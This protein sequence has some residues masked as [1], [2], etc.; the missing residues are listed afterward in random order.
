MGETACPNDA[1]VAFPDTSVSSEYDIYPFFR[2]CGTLIDQTVITLPFI[3]CLFILCLNVWLKANRRCSDVD[4]CAP[5]KHPP[6][7][8]LF[9]WENRS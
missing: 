5:I 3:V 6:S 9:L 7:L 8:H 2:Q 4:L 1:P